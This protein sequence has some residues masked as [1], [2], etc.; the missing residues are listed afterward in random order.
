MLFV[1]NKLADIEGDHSYVDQLI[2][3]GLDFNKNHFNTICDNFPNVTTLQFVDCNLALTKRLKDLP[4][5]EM[6]F[7]NCGFEDSDLQYLDDLENLEILNFIDIDELDLSYISDFSR[8]KS[9][10]LV[11]NIF[12]YDLGSLT[13]LQVEYLDIRGCDFDLDML[14]NNPHLKTLIIDEIDEKTLNEFQLAGVNVI[15]EEQPSG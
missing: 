6:T 3:N 1:L 10:S 11:Y 7:S 15:V 4:V 2:I 12:A 14:K 5:N 8:L 13:D 9:L